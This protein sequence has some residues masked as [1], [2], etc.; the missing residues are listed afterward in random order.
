MALGELVPDSSKKIGGSAISRRE[1]GQVKST[2]QL[3]SVQTD[4]QSGRGNHDA[5]FRNRFSVEKRWRS[6]G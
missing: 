3:C 1:A 4:Q 6:V 5:I 2:P